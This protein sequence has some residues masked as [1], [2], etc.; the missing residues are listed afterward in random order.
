M[1]QLSKR[2]L[3]RL[4]GLAAVAATATLVGCGKKEEAP[5]P[6]PAPQAA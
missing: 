1:T 6:A 5:P 4:G 2:A 3:I